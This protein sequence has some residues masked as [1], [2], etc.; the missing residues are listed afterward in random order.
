MYDGRKIKIL[1]VDDHPENLLALEAMLDE[2]AYELVQANSGE[3]ALKLVLDQKFAVI[4]LDA[5]MPGM[6][7]FETAVHI[8]KLERCKNTPIIFVTAFNKDEQDVRK[9]Y[10]LGAVDYIF[11]P[12]A[13][14][15]LKAKVKV[16]AELFD[17]TQ[18]LASARQNLFTLVEKSNEGILVLDMQGKIRFA[19]ITAA[20]ILGR[21]K[22]EL[23]DSPFGL[24]VLMD[25][26]TE[27]DLNRK[28]GK[29]GV[30]QLRGTLTEWEGEAAHLIS[31]RD[32]T[33]SRMQENQLRQSQKLEAVGTLAGGIAHD[34]N[35]IL[36]VIMGN[37][38]IASLNISEESPSQN[39]LREIFKA[40]ERARDLVRQI[41]N[42]SRHSEIDKIALDLIP[43]VKDALKFLRSAIPAHI[44][45]SQNLRPL[46]HQVLADPTQIHQVLLNLCT[47]AAQ[48]MDEKGGFIEVK[49]E[50]V[51]V[52]EDMV[53]EHQ[54]LSPGLYQRLTVTDTGFG[55]NRQIIE[56]IFEPF[57]TSK[58]I[59]KGTGLGLSVVHGI[60]QTHGGAILVFSQ[61]GIGTTFE[62][63]LPA[64][65][66]NLEQGDQKAITDQKAMSDAPLVLGEERILL[67]DDETSLVAIMEKT[68]TSF[69]YQV[70]GFT[71]S[72]E[73]LESFQSDPEKYALAIIDYAMPKIN[74]LTLAD[75]IM[76][77]RPDIP[78]IILTGLAGNIDIV[79]AESMGIKRILSKPLERNKLA[80]ALR[81]VL[82]EN[83]HD[84]SG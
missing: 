52:D 34:F 71:R 33:Q 30:G 77:I 7:G 68:I 70:R 20:E 42:F 78:V 6:D 76:E 28:G 27:I 39:N 26:T 43:L 29:T 11:K 50:E 3:M 19:N 24:P 4:L 83:P 22:E 45:I 1:A 66:D 14:E 74:G 69:G 5:K 48:A 49:L 80:I 41:L 55:M 63:Y 59:G 17:K 81:E 36:A 47:N 72:Q 21:S 51:M 46:R 56:R 40:S 79:R 2:P 13:P 84:L 65:V 60:V 8:R 58:E 61:P 67:V 64:L 38:E 32:V 25:E 37:A 44:D 62:V 73:A 10:L 15:A 18:R 57:Y 12:I 35:N 16:F 53:S 82:D 54:D 9:S 23:L 75:R 31:I